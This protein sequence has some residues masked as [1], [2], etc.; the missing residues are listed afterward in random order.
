MTLINPKDIKDDDKIFVK[1]WNLAYS[2]L[3]CKNY[4]HGFLLKGM[5]QLFRI[6]KRKRC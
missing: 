5:H 2:G 3:F 1:E 6:N 4:K